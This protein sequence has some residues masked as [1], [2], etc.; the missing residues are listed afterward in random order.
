MTGLSKPFGAA[1]C[2]EFSRRLY[3]SWMT[4]PDLTAQR[5]RHLEIR[6]ALPASEPVALRALSTTTGAREVLETAAAAVLDWDVAHAA[7]GAGR[8][9]H[10]PSPASVSQR[11]LITFFL[12]FFFQSF[13]GRSYSAHRGE[14]EHGQQQHCQHKRLIFQASYQ[15]THSDYPTGQR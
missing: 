5:A 14:H 13:T 7:R 11:L 10:H 12:S 3:G 4:H 2:P 15:K 8:L 1:D 6:E 9:S